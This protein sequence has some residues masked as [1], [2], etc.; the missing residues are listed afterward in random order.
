MKLFENWSISSI[1]KNTKAVVFTIITMAI[2]AFIISGIIVFI[3][4]TITLVLVI[5]TAVLLFVLFRVLSEN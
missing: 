5:L 2:S 4:V 1:W 3:P